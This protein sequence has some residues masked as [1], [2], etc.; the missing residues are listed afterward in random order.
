MAK[1]F[2]SCMCVYN[3]VIEA[4]SPEEAADILTERCYYDI[5]GV[6]AVTDTETNEY[7]EVE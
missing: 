1:Y 7:Y 3:D 2:V 6:I 5:D 4:D